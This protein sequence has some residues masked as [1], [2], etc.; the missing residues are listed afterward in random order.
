M[1]AWS[2]EHVWN[3]LRAWCV[4]APVAYGLFK[5][6]VNGERFISLYWDACRGLYTGAFKSVADKVCGG[7]LRAPSEADVVEVLKPIL[8]A[9]QSAADQDFLMSR[10]HW[11]RRRR[12]RHPSPRAVGF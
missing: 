5:A 7:D 4:P 12:S 8:R 10:G 6:G 1:K 11:V 2:A 3:W 9:G